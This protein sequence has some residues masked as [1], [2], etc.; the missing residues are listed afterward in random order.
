MKIHLLA[1]FV[2]FALNINAQ[3]KI[4][5]TDKKVAEAENKNETNTSFEKV[6]PRIKRPWGLGLGYFLNFDGTG[7]VISYTHFISPQLELGIELGTLAS[8][9]FNFTYAI[10]GKYH[11]RKSESTKPLSIFS[12]LNVISLSNSF[13]TN[14]ISIQTPVGIQYLNNNGFKYSIS[15]VPITNFENFETYFEVRAGYNFKKK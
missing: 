13:S 5:T 7:A 12:G 4:T 1:V 11:Y 8:A 3:D 2:L 14:Q 10:G 15:L 6:N 9:F